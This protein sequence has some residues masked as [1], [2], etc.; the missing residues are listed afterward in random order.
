MA[1]SPNIPQGNINR[2]I[3]S[4]V[5]DDFP[6]LNITPSFPDAHTASEMRQI[7]L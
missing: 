4:L 1:G 5:I 3:A 2:L 7:V 6:S